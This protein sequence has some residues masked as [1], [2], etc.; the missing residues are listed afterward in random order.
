MYNK[1][2]LIF[3]LITHGCIYA[4][5]NNFED[6]IRGIIRMHKEDTAEVNSLTN[7]SE[8]VEN[9]DSAIM[10]AEQGLLLARRINYRKGEADCLLSIAQG[11]TNFG[12]STQFALDGLEI[13]EEL[14]DQAG[15]ATS[16]LIIENDYWVGG[17]YKNALIHAFSGERVSEAG[18]VKG[19]ILF[20][21][22]PLAPLFLA[23]IGQIYLLDNNIDSAKYYTQ[24][25]INKNELL[26]GAVWGFPVYLLAMIQM[27]EGD[28][29]IALKNF[30]AAKALAIQN[31]IFIDTLQV[32]SGMST[33][34]LKMHELDS[35]IY[36]ARTVQQHW[37]NESEMK[38]LLEALQNLTT[39]YKWKGQK[40]STIKYIELRQSLKDSIFSQ[41]KEKELQN[42]TFNE[43]LKREEIL[44]AQAKYKSRIQ[45]YILVFGL[46]VVL[47]IAGIVWRNYLHR[48]R[49]YTLLEK[50]KLETDL[51]KQKAEA[52]LLELRSTQ[53]QLIQ[54]EKMASLGELTA[55]IAHEI[56]NP[57]NFVNNFSEVNRELIEELKGEARSGNNN[58][59]IAI[60]DDI[61]A[62]EEKI[63]HHGKRAD[64]IVKG[65]LQHSRSGTGQKEP[66]DINAVA[67]ECLRLSYHGFR[68]RKK[69]FQADLKT[70]FDESIVKIPLVQ[71]DMVRVLVNVYNNAFYAVSEKEKQQPDNYEP[72]ITVSTKGLD[73][74]VEIR[75]RDNGNG[76]P[77]KVIDKI[78][79]PFFTTKPTGQGTGLGL[80]LSYDII[81]AHGGEIKV[82]TKEG[83]G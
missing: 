70:D 72:T 73:D 17:D 74:K 81:K 78:F 9:I 68:A 59:V 71:Q 55:G 57:L 53:S 25:S 66:V 26:H 21:G 36:C 33:L 29:A 31:H 63:I 40:D 2:F 47:M 43:R 39:A 80:S 45:I 20:A 6:S 79:Q 7:L 65:M 54:S 82:E 38:N 56:Q 48:K 49:A 15:I 76:I 19:K 41:D 22:H 58:E 62:N 44:S 75:V 13:Y 4:Q 61:S 69:S 28:Y 8:E 35:A 83:E 52:T 3:F 37:N 64:A 23:E 5:Q 46:F 32:L 1:I 30:H 16:H 42:V 34:F 18:N 67:D 24:R 12:E 60:A 27:E 14:H 11:K 77:Q 10:Y 51:E 50:Q